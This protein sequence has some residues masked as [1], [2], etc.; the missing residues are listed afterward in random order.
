MCVSFNFMAFFYF[1]N[2]GTVEMKLSILIRELIYAL[3]LID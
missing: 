2:Y 3:L 1:I